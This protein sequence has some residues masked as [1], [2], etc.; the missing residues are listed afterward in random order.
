M[1]NIYKSRKISYTHY[2]HDTSYTHSLF[3]VMKNAQL[4][5][6]KKKLDGSFVNFFK[7]MYFCDRVNGLTLRVT[8]KRKSI[9]PHTHTKLTWHVLEIPI[10][11]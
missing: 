6:K 1:Q 11:E 9:Q 8:V 10:P 2:N 4:K 5:I 7:L 3:K